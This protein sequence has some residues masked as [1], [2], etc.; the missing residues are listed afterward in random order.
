[1]TRLR[2]RGLGG[3]RLRAHV[4]HGGYE[5]RTLISGIRLGGLCA[6]GLFEGPM[7]GER[8]LAWVTQG[9]A[10]TLR[11]GEV[12]ILDYPATHKIRGVREAIEATGARRPPEESRSNCGHTFPQ[13]DINL[14]RPRPYPSPQQVEDFCQGHR[15]ECLRHPFR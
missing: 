2:G 3:A 6:P 14:Q 4:L 9:F 13:S 12:A 10:P 1:M 11:P 5:T 15:Q 7:D 8:F